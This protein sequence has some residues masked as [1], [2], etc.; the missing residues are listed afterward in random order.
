MSS[1]EKF[2]PKSSVI[3]AWVMYIFIAVMVLQ[4]LV[5][6]SLI[7]GAVTVIAGGAAATFF[8]RVMHRPY[9]VIS[10]VDILIVNPVSTHRFSWLEIESIDTKYTMSVTVGDRI[11]N[12]WAAPAAGRIAARKV[13]SAEIKGLNIELAGTIAPGDLPRSDSGVAAY[14][15]RQKWNAARNR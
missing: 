8:Y 6:S 5:T 10:D 13:D 7:V 12:A 4:T 2:Q 11:V 14:L 3:S 9:I 15:A 1:G